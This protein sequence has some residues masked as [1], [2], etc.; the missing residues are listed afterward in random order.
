M[1]QIKLYFIF[2]LLIPIA[3]F[4]PVENSSKSNKGIVSDDVEKS[5][6]ILNDAHNLFKYVT[7]NVARLTLPYMLKI[8]EEV[9]V[10]RSCVRS[11]MRL[12]S[13]LKQNKGLTI[14]L[15]DSF[16]KPSGIFSG[17]TW[18][19]GDYDQCLNI[20]VKDHKIRKN[21][22][23]INTIH[24]KF[25]SLT[26]GYNSYKFS[27]VPEDTQNTKIFRMLED[28]L[29][30]FPLNK[31]FEM[32]NYKKVAFRVDIC[33][34]STCN[35]QDVENI[36][37]WAFRDPYRANVNFCKVKDQKITICTTQIICM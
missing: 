28:I 4:A 2:A 6:R 3:D 18:L 16:G 25:C 11:G 7:T 24:G 23:R 33:I 12:L 1:N 26:V 21:D 34:P 27:D 8:A 14:K 29:Q 5:G 19:H 30:P 37:Q 9:N 32:F 35:R 22:K 17:K 20:E 10:S 31:F 15:L 13:D 36:L